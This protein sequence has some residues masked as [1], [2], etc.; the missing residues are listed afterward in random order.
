MEKRV[1]PVHIYEPI[2]SDIAKNYIKHE[3]R[4]LLWRLPAEYFKK[5]DLDIENWTRS[6]E[7]GYPRDF[8]NGFHGFSMGFKLK[9]G[10]IYLITAENIHWTLEDMPLSKLNFG[11]EQAE[12]RHIRPG[13]L[14]A[15]EVLDFYNS[16]ENE[17]EKNRFLELNRKLSS[18][19][20]PR[21]TDPIIAFQKIEEGILVNS[22]HDGN[23]RLAKSVLERKDKILTYIGRY[24]TD[25]KVPKNYWIPTSLIMDNLYFA[26]LS[27]EQNDRLLFDKYMAILK[28]M[29]GKSE[30]VVYEMKDRALT[31]SQPFRDDVLRSL[32]LV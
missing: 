13:K 18:E 30:S 32:N 11:V 17:E 1:Y 31:K 3:F 8:W 16:R 6:P 15:N 28:D 22:V 25:N 10:L 14:P 27:Y 24:S 7:I 9:I 26:R 29:L 4:K 2:R 21:D 5:I 20:P 23:R 19:T 12:T